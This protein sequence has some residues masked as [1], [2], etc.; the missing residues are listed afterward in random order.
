MIAALEQSTSSDGPQ[1][2][3]MNASQAGFVYF[4]SLIPEQGYGDVGS[5]MTD[6]DDLGWLDDRISYIYLSPGQGATFYQYSDFESDA[7]PF[8]FV[9]DPTYGTEINLTGDFW[10]N[11]ISSIDVWGA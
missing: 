10:D 4:S 9:G 3:D 5:S 6:V 1:Q 11:R 2:Q 7:T 8:S